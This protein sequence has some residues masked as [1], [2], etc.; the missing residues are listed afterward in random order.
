MKNI[1]ILF[2]I[3][4]MATQMS[5]CKKNP[6]KTLPAA[7]QTGANTFG[8]LIDGEAYKVEGKYVDNFVS[9]TTGI[10]FGKPTNASFF[11]NTKGCKIPSFSINIFKFPI[12]EGEYKFAKPITGNDNYADIETAGSADY[13]R[14]P[15]SNSGSVII[16]KYDGNIIAGTFSFKATNANGV[17]KHITDGRFDISLK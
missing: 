16:T 3:I 7:T 13:L 14:T 5:S 1:I 12:S 15:D 2:T 11:L 4:I 6:L 8:C 10:Y 17:V 9:C